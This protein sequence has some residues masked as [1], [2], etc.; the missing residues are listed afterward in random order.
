MPP[1]NDKK[2]GPVLQAAL[3]ELVLGWPGVTTSKMFGSRAYRAQGVLFAM[4]GGAGLILTKMQ[5]DQR[6]AAVKKHHARTFVGHG[7]EI[8]AWVE[9]PLEDGAALASIAPLVRH[10]Y[11]NALAEAGAP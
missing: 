6:E 10:A 1:L 4:I 5:P 2:K 7:R 3:D 8:P 11:E 9:F